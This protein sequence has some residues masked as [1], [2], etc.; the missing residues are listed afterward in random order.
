MP[1]PK[2]GYY[3][4]D[5][6]RVPGVTTIIGRFKE[7]GALIRWAFNQGKEGKDLYETRDKAADIGSAAHAMV[8]AQING[9]DP[10]E[11]LMLLTSGP[12]FTEKAMSA[13]GAYSKWAS[14]TQL[15]IVE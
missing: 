1:T 10:H 12:E 5:G 7:S 3:L 6:T 8:E 9:D 14:M 13:F 4:K 11:V 2:E 15:G